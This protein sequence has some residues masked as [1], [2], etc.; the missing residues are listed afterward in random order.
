MLTD[1]DKIIP[2]L[3]DFIDNDSSGNLSTSYKRTREQTSEQSSDPRRR[4]QAYLL[5][6]DYRNKV[7]L[8]KEPMEDRGS[9]RP[10]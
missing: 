6:H 2:F 5:V 4:G 9:E 1:F 8:T 3:L 10:G 7:K